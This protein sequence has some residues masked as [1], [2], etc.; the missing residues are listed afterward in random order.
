MQK[1][2]KNYIIF[3]YDESKSNLNKLKHGL[4]FETAKKLW[5]DSNLVEV[6]VTFS[7]EIRV[8]I[9]G[10]IDNKLWTAVITQR[11]SRVRIISV[12]RARKNEEKEY[13]SQGI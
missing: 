5:S 12:R 7:K 9:T 6:A 10:M 1:R 13:Y 11:G 4:D 2:D 8:L 3:E